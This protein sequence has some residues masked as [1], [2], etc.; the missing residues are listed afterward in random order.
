VLELVDHLEESGRDERRRDPDR[1]GEQD[2]PQIGPAAE[3]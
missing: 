1:G 3:R 2:Q